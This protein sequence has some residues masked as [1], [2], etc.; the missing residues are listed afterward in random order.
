MLT[1]LKQTGARIRAF[2]RTSDLDRDLDQELESHLAMLG[3]DNIRRGMTPDEA[4]R[5]ARLQVGALS[6]LREA[7]REARGLPLFESILQDLRYTF[8][9]LRRDAGFT[10]FSVLI[11]GL[12]VGASTTIFSVVN[13]LLIRSVPFRDAGR[14]VWIGNTADDGVAEWRVQVGHFLDLREQS[15]SFSDLAAYY[16]H[17]RAGGSKLT[18]DGEPERLTGVPVS[19]N[20]FPFLGVKPLLGRPFNEDEC[21]WNGPSV[22]LLSYGFWKRRYNFDPG[23]V[24]RAIT[25]ADAPATVVGVLPQSFDFASVFAPGSQIDLYFPYPLG[26]E[27]NRNGNTLAVMGRLSP[28]ATIQSAQAE[29]NILAEQLQS[30][31][32]ERNSFRPRLSAL[33][34]H[35]TGRLRPALL[36]LAFAVGIVMLIVCANLSNLQLARL[37]MRQKEMAVRVALGASRNRLIRQMFTESVVLSACGAAIGLILAVA[38]TRVLARLNAVSIPL[39]ENIQIDNRALGFTLLIAVLTGLVLGLAPALQVPALAVHD[40]LKDGNRGAFGGRRHSR[41]RAVL[42]VSEI[43][44]ACV[45]LVGAGLLIHSF[46]QVLNVDLGFQPGRAAAIRIDPSSQYSTLPQRNAYYDEA[47]RRVRSTPGIEAA[48][49]AELLPFAGDKSWDVAGKGQLYS[50]GHYPEGFIRVVSD[51]YLGAMGIPLLAG[52]EFTERDGPTG[53]PVTLVNETL[54]ATL[55]PGQDPLGQE[56][57]QDGGRR[58]VGVVGNVRHG[59]LEQVSGCEMYLPIRQTKAYGSVQLVVRTAL[60]PAALASAVREALKPIEPNLPWNEFR[61]LQQL[62]DKAVSPRRFVVILLSGFSAF[63]LI[64]ASLGIYGVISY[65]VNQRTQEIGIRMALGASGGDLQARVILQTLRFAGI[66]VLIGLAASWMLSRTL[67]GLLFGVSPTD[68]VT[69]AGTVVVLVAVAAVAGYIPARR[70]SRIDPMAALRSN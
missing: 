29:L 4:R 41:I 39:L 28:N 12:G 14:L 58:V 55:W 20:F 57:T 15:S 22:V 54:A 43:S 36:V 16:G 9:T 1:G 68:P 30:Q 2:F 70:A 31:H 65:S 51:G 8:R 48:A 49:V 44:F 11:V 34:E 53:E 18:G 61:T 60:P 24:G 21:K 47:L 63:A 62:V 13:A 23:I 7:H 40:A 32:P 67:S 46:V 59:A 52:R 45:L 25:L 64:L 27:T 6:Q 26:E 10:I 66:G 19:Q 35:V 69:L 3:E 38:G 50:N 56:V 37:A 17:Y 42:V 33:E 5:A